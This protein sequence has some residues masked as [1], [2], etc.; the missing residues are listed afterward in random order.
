M[1]DRV[2]MSFDDLMGMLGDVAAYIAEHDD[3]S[4]AWR[5][6]YVRETTSALYR[7]DREFFDWEE[8][9][10]TRDLLGDEVF[11]IWTNLK[12]THWLG[13]HRIIGEAFLRLDE[14]DRDEGSAS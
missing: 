6:A 12:L 2:A 4:S 11:E 13:V 1:S 10:L 7:L 8:A 14:V 3:K 9:L 5:S